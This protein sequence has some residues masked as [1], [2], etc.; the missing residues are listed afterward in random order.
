[1]LSIEKVISQKFKGK[2]RQLQHTGVVVRAAHNRSLDSDS[3]RLWLKL[4]A[5]PISLE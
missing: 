4:E 2:I 5:Q 1:M 3:E